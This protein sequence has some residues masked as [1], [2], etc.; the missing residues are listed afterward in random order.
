[1]IYIF[2]ALYCE[3]GNIIERYKLNKC[4][5]I[6]VFQVFKNDAEGICLTITGSGMCEAAAAVSYICAYFNADV[7]D[8][9]INTGICAGRGKCGSY[10]INKITDY[11][12][13]RT[14]YPDMLYRTDYPEAELMSVPVVAD[15]EF[16]AKNNDVLIDMEAAGIY[17]AA[18][19]FVPPHHMFYIKTVSDEGDAA[20]VHRDYVN[21]LMRKEEDKLYGLIGLIRGLAEEKSV[22]AENMLKRDGF[23]EKLSRDM[24]CTET[25]KNDFFK[26]IMYLELSKTDYRARIDELY[27]NGILPCSNKNEGKACLDELR[28]ELL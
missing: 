1:M 22:P 26:L 27:G 18:I 10:L 6:S 25:M 12:T 16:L 13:K 2:Q 14:Y 23:F 5:D 20:A 9:I 7:S 11:T 19:H 8:F 21:R 17:Q 28:R 4:T 3:A 15:E 24:R